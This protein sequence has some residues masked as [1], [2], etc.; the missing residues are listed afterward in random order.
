MA[1]KNKNY[2]YEIRKSEGQRTAVYKQI[3]EQFG[4]TGS[5]MEFSLFAKLN[6]EEKQE[7]CNLVFM[8]DAESSHL[9]FPLVRDKEISSKDSA[10]Y[11]IYAMRAVTEHCAKHNVPAVDYISSTQNSTTAATFGFTEKTETCEIG[12]CE[13]YEFSKV[14]TKPAKKEEPKAEKTETPRVQ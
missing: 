14:Q 1:T 12:G 11:S 5:L 4:H 3:F 9:L 10:L 2:V 8:V 13:F 7:L 6:E